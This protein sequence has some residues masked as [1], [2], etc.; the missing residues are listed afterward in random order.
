[1][2]QK[3]CIDRFE[4]AL[5]VLLVNEKP[6]VFPKSLLPHQARAGDWLQVE[7]EAGRLVSAQLDPGEKARTAA[8]IQAKL[9]R[10]R[11]G[12]HL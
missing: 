7:I 2:S 12:D 5:A 11:R 10:L 4:G 8:R 6:L 3:A 9:A 1:M